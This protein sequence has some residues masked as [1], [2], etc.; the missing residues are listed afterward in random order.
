MPKNSEILDE[1]DSQLLEEIRE[2]A[3][4]NLAP[5]DIALKVGIQ[6]ADF[7]RLWRDESS[8]IREY[9]DKGRLDLKSD[10][11]EVLNAQAFEGNKTAIQ[12][13]ARLIEEQEFEAKKKEI[14]GLE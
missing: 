7:L 4:C 2:L 8:V 13:Q 11:M 3:A 1:L 10:Q 5:S 6:K 14:F 12:I 9:Y